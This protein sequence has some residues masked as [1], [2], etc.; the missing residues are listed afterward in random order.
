[1]GDPHR[2]IIGEVNAQSTSDLLRAPRRSPASVLTRSVTTP[3]PAH[4]RARDAPVRALHFPGKPVLHIASQLRVE[5]ELGRLRSPG[6]PV[7]MRLRG[8]GRYSERPLRSAAF[9]CSSLEIVDG[10]R[11][12]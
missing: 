9:R 4:L 12:S 7:G 11:P 3:T 2:L 6:A 8:R 1:M 10:A 5:R